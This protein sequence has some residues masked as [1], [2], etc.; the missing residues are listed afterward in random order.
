M[1]MPKKL[2]GDASSQPCVLDDTQVHLDVLF[3]PQRRVPVRLDARRD[4]PN[5]PHPLLVLHCCLQA[6]SQPC[7][8]AERVLERRLRGAVFH[9]IHDCVDAEHLQT[10]ECR[11]E[12]PPV[13]VVREPT[14]RHG[15][16][17]SEAV[18][19]I[20]QPRVGLAAVCDVQLVIV[21]RVVIAES[22]EHNAVR[23]GPFEGLRKRSS[24]GADGASDV[25]VRIRHLVLVVPREIA[26]K[27]DKFRTV[28]HL[29]R[30]FDRARP[31]LL[32]WIARGVAVRVRSRVGSAEAPLEVAH[33][34][35][36]PVLLAD[37][38]I[39]IHM[40]IRKPYEKPTLRGT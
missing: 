39:W 5:D 32:R 1:N 16:V 21:R 35:I 30:R 4:V 13:S 29:L 34:G 24:D 8:L 15:V 2:S 33:G 10:A 37:A 6:L 31:Q 14:P 28:A 36:V 20:R 25:G 11:L 3:L 17:R 27:H 18:G 9:G 26:G 7:E 23:L 22:P 19:D 12:E 38:V 40:D